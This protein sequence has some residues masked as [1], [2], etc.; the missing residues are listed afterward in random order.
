[1]KIIFEEIEDRLLKIKFNPGINRLELIRML[2][3]ETEWEVDNKD[4]RRSQ[5]NNVKNTKLIE[6]KNFLQSNEV[7]K[8]VIDRYYKIR[9]SIEGDYNLSQTNMYESTTTGCLFTRDLPGFDIPIHTDPIWLAFTGVI[10]FT[11]TDD[12]LL[13]SYFYDSNKQEIF[14]MTTNYGD[15]WIQH[16]ANSSWHSGGNQRS[17]TVRYSLIFSIQLVYGKNKERVK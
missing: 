2:E 8:E 17:D 16:N 6:I 10:F 14:R 12:P 13:A 9:P 5:L 15:G 4:C 7:A 3:E 11:E 1:M